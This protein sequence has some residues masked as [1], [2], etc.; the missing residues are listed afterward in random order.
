MAFVNQTT[1]NDEGAGT[2]VASSAFV[3]T[4]GNTIAVAAGTYFSDAVVSTVTDTAGNTYAKKHERKTQGSVEIWVATNVTGHATNVVTVTFT[5]SVGSRRSLCLAQFSGRNR[6]L[7]N[8]VGGTADGTQ[9]SG[10]SVT[11]GSFTPSAAACDMFAGVSDQGGT[12]AGTADANYA[13]F[14]NNVDVSS[15]TRVNAPGTSQTASMSWTGTS[16]ADLALVALLAAEVYAASGALALSFTL[17][18]APLV[19]KEVSGSPAC[20]FALSGNPTTFMPAASLGLLPG[21]TRF[22]EAAFLDSW[23]RSALPYQPQLWL[24]L[25]TTNPTDEGGGV[26]V[27][28]GNYGRRI[29]ERGDTRW[30]VPGGSPSQV[31]NLLHIEWNQVTWTETVVGW[32]VWDAQTGGNLLFWYDSINVNVSAT[33]ALHLM[34]GALIFGMN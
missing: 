12:S 14:Q 17:T 30:S 18:G 5:A 26:E 19:I 34:P 6:V 15:E 13:N 21:A 29:L 25:F 24:G 2:T 31:T 16:A 1:G 32:G 27:A 10:T 23:F 20:A 22:L 9:V 4:A 3:A 8:V 7:T 33:Y 11:S 28:G